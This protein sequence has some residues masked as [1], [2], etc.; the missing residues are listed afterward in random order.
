M[1]SDSHNQ[2]VD[3]AW[4]PGTVLLEELS[5][6]GEVAEV[7][8]Q[9]KPSSDP[10]DPL[11]WPLWRKN[12]NF[13]LA[14]Y[15]AMMVL[16]LIDVAT[17]TWE[18][19][20]QELGF[21][22]VLLNDS[23]A[24][25]CASLSIG[26]IILVPFSLKYG[27][28]PVYILSTAAQCG[29]CV[30]LARMQNVADLMLSNILTCIVGALSEVLVQMTVAD[31]YFIHHR[32][33][34]NTIYYW[35][36]NLG[37]TF[38]PLA[39]GYIIPSQGWRW[40]WWWMVILL[41]AG[42]VAFTFCYE[43][44]MFSRRIEG[45]AVPDKV[46]PEQPLDKMDT[47]MSLPDADKA[48]AAHG[49]STAV[50]IDTSIPKKTYWQKL[51]LW[52]TSPM[53]LSQMARQTYQPLVIL[54]SF[55]AVTFMALEY[56]MLNACT[57]IPVTTYSSVMTLPPYNFNPQQIGLMG[58]PLFV[59][60]TLGALAC[61]PLS[62]S[63]V[64]YLAKRRQG[65]Y[66]PEMRLWLALVCTPLVPAG[67]FMFGIGLNNQSHWWLPA[68][69]LGIS[70]FGIVPGSSSALTY[71]TDAYTDIVPDFMVGITSVSNLISMLFVFIQTPWSQKTGLSWF[72]VAF[73]LI[74][75][76][77]MLGNLIF[78]YFGKRFRVR[79]ASKYLSY[80]DRKALVPSVM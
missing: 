14:C 36:I 23:Y 4:P 72:Y 19:V 57:T 13:G 67:L 52:S 76:A 46:P 5:R 39:G 59:G 20:K 3:P 18:P 79:F 41:F 42:L 62:D 1:P 64:L 44:T 24:A 60:T 77:I 74:V 73:G 58:M 7:I 43:E 80:T 6:P 25:G 50:R 56:G 48:Q 54:F 65:I 30:W 17:V 16:A 11:N 27:R 8:L 40:V 37:A 63:L 38:S 35:C 26:A 28:R 34:A 68:L 51:P 21:S 45:I 9:P 49:E 71:L 12:L 31:V 70:S 15:Y 32:G 2:D 69:G 78:I 53:P 22:Y 47:E 10:N 61:G 29:L 33:T 55:P 75:T 66:E